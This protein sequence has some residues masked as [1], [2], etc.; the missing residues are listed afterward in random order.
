MFFMKGRIVTWTIYD[1]EDIKPEYF[2]MGTS[3][4]PFIAIYQR[5]K[6][7]I[8][9]IFGEG[10]NID[11]VSDSLFDVMDAD[12]GVLYIGADGWKDDGNCKKEIN[13]VI[14]NSKEAQR[15]DFEAVKKALDEMLLIPED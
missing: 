11:E 3:H 15:D 9:S 13:D 10:E 12:R 2:K 7:V 5:D 1:E 14:V 4:C 6:G 8:S